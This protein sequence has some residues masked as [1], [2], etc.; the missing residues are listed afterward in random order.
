MRKIVIFII[1]SSII[2]ITGC[3][4]E[5]SP[6]SPLEGGSDLIV[7]RAYVY[8][9][10]TVSDIKITSTLPLGSEEQSAP[11]INDAQIAIIKN[12]TR[13]VL[14]TSPGDS[15]Y[16][17]Y[18]SSDLTIQT[19]DKLKIEVNYFDRVATGGTVVPEPTRGLS[20]SKD[21]LVVP[22]FSGFGFGMGGFNI[23]TTRIRLTVS[24]E[25]NNN[26]LH[27]ITVENVESD[28]Q[29]IDTGMPFFRSRR[30][31][32][33]PTSR[34]NYIISFMNVT[35]LGRHCVKVY[36]INQE[37]ADLYGSRTQN[38]R[39]LNEPLTNIKNGLGVF[40]AFNSESVFFNVT[41]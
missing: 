18:S 26:S 19:G 7:I 2:G 28:P 41:Q 12:G 1:I 24:W 10:E 17:H 20:I 38:S 5:S 34:T 27:F 6:I 22:D 32:S 30:F 21:E 9:G 16:Y 25:N 4:Q 35:H 36:R 8:A 31:I 15:G 23:D 39:D 14:Q 40:S 29:Q 3:S 13:Y 33:Q 11:P 37:Y